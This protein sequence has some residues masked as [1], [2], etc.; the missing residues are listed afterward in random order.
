[1]VCLSLPLL[2]MDS[3]RPQR[4]R[5]AQVCCTQHFAVEAR[6]GT[7]TRGIGSEGW[8]WCCSGHESGVVPTGMG[9]HP[10]VPRQG[11]LRTQGPVRGLAVLQV[12][13]TLYPPIPV[14]CLQDLGSGQKIAGLCRGPPRGQLQPLTFSLENGD[15]L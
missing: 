15:P 4:T 7:G 3:C 11:L 13:P 2:A 14:G 8:N 5:G 12:P 6:F 9:Q 10:L 1:M